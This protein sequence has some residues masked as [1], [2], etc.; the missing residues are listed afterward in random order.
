MIG[1]TGDARH[2]VR[3]CPSCQN[4]R[5]S[6]ITYCTFCHPE[7]AKANAFD[8]FGG[9][10]GQVCCPVI[11]WILNELKFDECLSAVQQID[12][13]L[14]GNE[15]S[16]KGVAAPPSSSSSR[17]VKDIEQPKSGSLNRR[18]IDVG[19]PC[20]TDV[21]PSGDVGGISGNIVGDDGPAAP[22][23]LLPTMLSSM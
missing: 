11:G 18:D 9:T 6:S 2:F 13:H 3:E 12:R 14:Q 23:R 10:N 16:A 4:T 1:T 15:L 19:G 21:Y 17:N 22:I 20:P 7:P 8:M 5:C